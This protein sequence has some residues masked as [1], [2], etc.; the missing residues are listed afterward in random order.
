MLR[1]RLGPGRH[2]PPIVASPPVC[3][4]GIDPK[5]PANARV[6][7]S[8]APVSDYHRLRL[9]EH[10]GCAISGTTRRAAPLMLGP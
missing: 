10:V 2:R 4:T 3:V 7:A 8:R 1:F 9:L 5:T 6:R